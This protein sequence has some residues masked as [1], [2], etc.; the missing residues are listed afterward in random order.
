MHENDH[1]ASRF[2]VSSSWS[3]VF[4]SSHAISDTGHRDLPNSYFSETVWQIV[5][6]IRRVFQKYAIRAEK[7]KSEV[8]FIRAFT[9]T[10]QAAPVHDPGNKRHVV[11]D[12]E[13]N[14]PPPLHSMTRTDTRW[15]E[16]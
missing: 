15:V 2:A 10:S 8:E 14:L 7:L 1:D 16:L 5:W 6:L 3:N 4:F 13:H 12:S 9:A 11:C